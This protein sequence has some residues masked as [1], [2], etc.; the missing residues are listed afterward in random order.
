MSEVEEVSDA[1]AALMKAMRGDG[2]VS[3]EKRQ[4]KFWISVAL[5]NDSHITSS[6][7]KAKAASLSDGWDGIAAQ[8]GGPEPSGFCRVGGC[9][10]TAAAGAMCARCERVFTDDEAD[11]PDEVLDESIAEHYREKL[12]TGNWEESNDE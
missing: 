6:V 1:V 7:A 3:V 12:R 5:A 9:D 2:N 4:G 11:I 10:Q 8:R